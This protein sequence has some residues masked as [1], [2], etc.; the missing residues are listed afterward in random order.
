MASIYESTSTHRH[1]VRNDTRPMSTL[2][3]DA[4]RQLSQL[5]RNELALAKAEVSEN[6]RNAVRG[7]VM[8]GVAAVVAL[9]ALFVLMLSLAALLVELG[10]VPWLAYL[11]TAAVGFVIAGILAA[12]GMS[13]LR[14]DMLMPNRTI[15][16]LHRDA[17]T[18]K[19]H[20]QGHEG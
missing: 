17:A 7:G 2:I 12:V 18:M 9:P 14:A 15:N 4:L 6:A 16:Q 5:M 1:E 19:A 20:M 8:I 11:I 13:R 3:S 10:L